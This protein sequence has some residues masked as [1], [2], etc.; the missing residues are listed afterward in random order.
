ML[1]DREDPVM[2]ALLYREPVD[3]VL[4]V[5]N[6]MAKNKG[7]HQPYEQLPIQRLLLDL[8]K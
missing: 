2:D 4:H 5:L 1:A 3:D 6:D 7:H 8:W